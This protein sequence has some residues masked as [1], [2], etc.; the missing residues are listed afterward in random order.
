MLQQ[1]Q[2][3]REA[4]VG[5]Q[6]TWRQIPLFAVGYGMII[7]NP[8]DWTFHQTLLEKQRQTPFPPKTGTTLPSTVHVRNHRAETALKAGTLESFALS[9]PYKTNNSIS[10]CLPE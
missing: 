7:S 1:P 8:I 3:Y 2:H 6:E 9:L 5:T 10:I 4:G